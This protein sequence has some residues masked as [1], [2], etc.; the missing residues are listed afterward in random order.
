MI[1]AIKREMKLVGIYKNSIALICLL[2]PLVIYLIP[3]LRSIR[4]LSKINTEIL[5]HTGLIGVPTYLVFYVI[6]ETVKCERES[7]SIERAVALW[8][9]RKFIYAKS[10]VS[11]SLGIVSEL[12][13]IIIFSILQRGGISISTF[14]LLLS[15][16]NIL[17]FSWIGTMIMY[18][19]DNLFA[20]LFIACVP[21]I[22]LTVALTQFNIL[23]LTFILLELGIGCFL[24]IQLNK[25]VISGNIDW[26]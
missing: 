8:G 10:I 16:I 17:L 20:S 19:T 5:F 13:F 6:Y 3:Y 23:L 4:D 21:F 22:F 9:I 15:T 2:G 7:K 25:K 12:L 18:I 14:F 11:G 1:T 24:K 26:L